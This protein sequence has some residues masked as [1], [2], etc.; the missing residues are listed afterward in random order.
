MIEVIKKFQFEKKLEKRRKELCPMRLALLNSQK[1]SDSPA[2]V[3]TP[4]KVQALRDLEEN[5]FT[6]NRINYNFDATSPYFVNITHRKFSRSKSANSTVD[7]DETPTENLNLFDLTEKNLHEFSKT[8]QTVIVQ[9]ELAIS[10]RRSYI[11]GM[12]K[13]FTTFNRH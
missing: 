13:E 4:T 2:R 6:P 8:S 10:K 5:K 12:L 3:H 7:A 9:D 11:S 1:L